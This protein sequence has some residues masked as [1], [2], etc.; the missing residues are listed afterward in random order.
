MDSHFSAHFGKNATLSYQFG[1]RVETENVVEKLTKELR[2]K[3][4]LQVRNAEKRISA[5]NCNIYRDHICHSKEARRK[6]LHDVKLEE[7]CNKVNDLELE[8]ANVLLATG[9]AHRAAKHSVK[10]SNLEVLVEHQTNIERKKQ[11]T[12]LEKNAL[13]KLR[14][15]DSQTQAREKERLE[16]IHS[17]RQIV[18]LDRENARACAEARMAR[19]QLANQKKSAEMASRVCVINHRSTSV[20]SADSIQLRGPVKIKSRVIRHGPNDS[21]AIMSTPAVEE[22]LTWRR[23]WSRCMKEL[24]STKAKKARE[25]EAKKAIVKVAQVQYLESEL[26]L[27]YAA[28]RAGPREQRI[29]SGDKVTLVHL[30]YRCIKQ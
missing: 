9:A 24:T 28:D 5:K 6:Q 17:K 22:D 16:R 11:A 15:S 21:L 2:I 19:E 27:L 7:K 14:E 25:V 13:E 18:E 26:A 1:G 23:M 3:R 10:R 4:L 8:W 20:Q 12:L 29:R 30:F